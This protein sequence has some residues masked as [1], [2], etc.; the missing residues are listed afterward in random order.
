MSTDTVSAFGGIGAVNKK[1]DAEVS[2]SV[3]EVFSEVLVAPEFDAE[4]L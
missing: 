4:A 2:A 1:V 3:I